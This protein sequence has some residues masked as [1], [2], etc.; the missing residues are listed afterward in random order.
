M[1]PVVYDDMETESAPPNKSNRTDEGPNVKEHTDAKEVQHNGNNDTMDVKMEIS[2]SNLSKGIKAEQSA[3]LINFDEAR[4][5]LL[6]I[7][8]Y[9]VIPAH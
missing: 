3:N 9:I 6:L 8:L 1:E 7:P 2:P 5:I 4:I